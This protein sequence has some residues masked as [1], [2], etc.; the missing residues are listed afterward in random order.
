LV[1]PL[2]LPDNRGYIEVSNGE[3]LPGPELHLNDEVYWP[4]GDCFEIAKVILEEYCFHKEMSVDFPD[5]Q[6]AIL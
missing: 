1:D 4:H 3:V 2:D 5:K 6:T